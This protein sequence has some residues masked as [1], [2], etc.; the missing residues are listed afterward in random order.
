LKVKVI[1]QAASH[2]CKYTGAAVTVFPAEYRLTAAEGS[3]NNTV[4]LTPP[5]R[6]DL[7]N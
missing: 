4:A 6:L 3:I 7:G 2:S 5:E 1:R